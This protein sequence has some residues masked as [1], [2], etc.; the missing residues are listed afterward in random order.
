MAERDSHPP[1]TFSWAELAT[2]DA[3]A[4][5]AFY[6]RLFG[7]E[8]DDF[9]MGEGMVYSMARVGTRF[10]A[11]LYRSDEHRHWASY[12]TVESADE[13]AARAKELGGS[14][15]SEPFD[16]MDVGRMAVVIDPQG[17]GL[18]IWEPRRHV[19][20]GLVNAPGAL[21][22][23][24][25]A[26]TDLAAAKRFYGELFGWQY[27]GNVIL[28]GA[29]NNGDMSQMPD[30]PPA[31]SVC[32]GCDD[33]EAAVATALEDGAQQIIAPTSMGDSGSYAVLADPQGVPFAV[34][35]G[36]FED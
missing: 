21:S 3:D 36:R 9:P 19:G 20:A 22:W 23:N 33:T 29:R 7:W 15:I 30:M 12:V 6:A 35:A 17:A 2:P 31:W 10:V 16:V 24:S 25:L 34:F 13:T 27:D 14:L 26:T 11:A 28:N 8:Y 18:A 4:A 32:F 5:K 1:G